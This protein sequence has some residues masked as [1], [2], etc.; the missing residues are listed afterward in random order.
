[1]FS[2]NRCSFPGCGWACKYMSYNDGISRYGFEARTSPAD[3]SV[4]CSPGRRVQISRSFPAFGIFEG[5]GPADS[6]PANGL[7]CAIRLLFEPLL[8]PAPKPGI[9]ALAPPLIA[10]PNAAGDP[11]PPNCCSS[12]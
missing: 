10:E 3:W 6:S 9:P 4:A 1:T 2:P 12:C 11:P 8:N 7:S 5:V